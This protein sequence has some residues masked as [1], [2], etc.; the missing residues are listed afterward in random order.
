[1]STQNLRT[2]QP[3]TAQLSQY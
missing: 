3:S 1:M 2:P